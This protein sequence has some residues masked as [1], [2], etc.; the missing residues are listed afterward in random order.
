ML[1]ELR[2]LRELIVNNSDRASI[3]EALDAVVLKYNECTSKLD[4]IKNSLDV[5]LDD[6]SLNI[7]SLEFDLFAT[8]Q[9]LDDER[10]K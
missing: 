5:N 6:L 7:K 3:I 1:K 9:E 2:S 8:Q 4:A 10:R